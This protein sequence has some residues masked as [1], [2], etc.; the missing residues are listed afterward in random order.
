MGND[1]GV[2]AEADG[3]NA[4]GEFF[5]PT[6]LGAKPADFPGTSLNLTKE[7]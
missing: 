3:P 5:S 1:D 4:D 6:Q 7:F 2:L